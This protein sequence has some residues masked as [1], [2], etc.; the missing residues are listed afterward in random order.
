[1]HGY[2]RPI[3]WTRTRSSKWE[4]HALQ[5]RG[6]A[7]PYGP[8]RHDSDI[9]TVVMRALCMI[10]KGLRDARTLALQGESMAVG[11]VEVDDRL[12]LPVAWVE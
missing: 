11:R 4:N 12:D 5:S 9:H 3:N 10:F 2:K 1:M 8:R 7:Q 6:V